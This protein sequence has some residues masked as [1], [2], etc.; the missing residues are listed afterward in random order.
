VAT[1]N[2]S[3]GI[4]LN[5]L[6]IALGSPLVFSYLPAIS[7]LTV[8]GLNSG[9]N[10]FQNGTADFFLSLTGLTDHDFYGSGF[11][12]TQPGYGGYFPAHLVVTVTPGAVATT[13][14]PAAL[15]L[16]IGALG[17][18]GWLGWRRRQAV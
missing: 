15:P 9:A 13:P 4:H 10:G 16:F 6:S 17:S 2:E 12:Y 3:A 14:I 1:T 11:A 5:N 8:G 7:A 18:L